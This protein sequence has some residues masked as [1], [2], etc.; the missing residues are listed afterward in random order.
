MK[1]PRSRAV[2][3]L[4]FLYIAVTLT[5][6]IV[7]SV[8]LIVGYF[9]LRHQIREPLEIAFERP[10]VSSITPAAKQAG[11]LVGDT[12]E[13]INGIPYRG[14]A[15]WQRVRWY[16][17]P[18]EVLQL[19]LR[20]KDGTET[21]VSIPLEG[22]V[23]GALANETL[24]RIHVGEVAFVTFLHIVVP[25]FCLAL[26]YWVALARPHDPNAWFILILLSFPET[27]IS[28]ST[29]NWWPGVWFPLRLAWHI[30][31]EILA[32]GALL[33]LGLLFPERSR[34]DLRLPWLKWLIAAVLICGIAVGLTTDYSAWYD[35]HLIPDRAAIDR[36][37]D[38]VL[39][40]TTIIC[41][42]LY[43]IAI[44]DKLRTASSPDARRRL[45]LLCIGSVVGLGSI[46]V[47]FGLL[48]WFGV[49]GSVRY[50]MA[51]ISQRRF[52]ARLPAKPGLSRRRTASYGRAH[53]AAHRH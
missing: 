53:S 45:R 2:Y 46:L 24:N 13:S 44:F 29:Y 38:K 21:A 28:V 16:A 10:I 9:D 18:G 48:P 37:N 5:Y 50:S 1:S 49:D 26:G 15:L 34:I 43:W 27:F 14:R 3:G 25:L 12:V 52:N 36:L 22:Y 20:R 19:G 35:L 51:R 23:K 41:L 33:W 31:L 39:N 30:I 6:Q 4:L 17:H 11:V 32:A 42:T 47:I 40:W 8:S 7:A